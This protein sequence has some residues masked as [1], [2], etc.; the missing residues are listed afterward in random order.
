MFSTI[1]N[2]LSHFRGNVKK[3]TFYTFSDIVFGTIGEDILPLLD[4]VLGDKDLV[5]IVNKNA[6]F[7]LLLKQSKVQ[8]KNNFT[9]LEQIA[10]NF[11]QIYKARFQVKELINK[12]VSN[13][14]VSDV[15]MSKDAATIKILTDLF[16]MSSYFLDFLYFIMLDP[17]T[18]D[19]P[20]VIT[21]R[22]RAGLV[23]FTNLY[24]DYAF[25]FDKIVNGIK[26]MVNTT[27][28]FKNTEV[29]NMMKTIELTKV[30]TA[31]KL[32]FNGFINNPIYHLRM[33][34]IDRDYRK[35]S[36]IKDKKQLIELK[37]MELKLQANDEFNPELSKQIK[38]YENKIVEMER[39]IQELENGEAVDALPEQT[40]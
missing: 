15:M 4:K 32:P 28:E 17:K 24:R 19:I 2:G 22:I 18:T 3:E 5:P 38:Y 23:N 9:G 29:E 14:V 33:W 10:S 31:P 36:V 16:S 39:D 7:T 27:I 26:S 1:I 20:R 11:N 37:L 30:G 35:A 25:K 34:L 40:A 12:H 6:L 8:A 13:T 21:N